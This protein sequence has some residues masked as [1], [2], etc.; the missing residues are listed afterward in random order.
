MVGTRRNHL[1]QLKE[2][3]RTASK[4]TQSITTYMHHLKQTA[5]LLASLGSPVSV[6]D[7]TDYVLH[8]LDDGYRA[9]IDAVNA[10]DTPINFDDL[11]ERLLI[12]ELSIGAA[13]RQTPAPLTALNAQ[14][15]PNSNDKSQHGQNPAQSTQRTGTRKPFLGRCQC[16]KKTSNR[17]KEGL[18]PLENNFR[19]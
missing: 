18:S 12:Q 17:I 4:G 11:H 13:Q 3:L 10:R 19:I 1:K 16:I 2:R 15:R 5:D 6:E 8:G 14:A 9:I 7:M